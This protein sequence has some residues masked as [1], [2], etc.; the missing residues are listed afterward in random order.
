M[1]TLDRTKVQ[2]SSGKKGDYIKSMVY[3]GLDGIITTF[4]VVAGVVGGA[5]DLRIIIILGFSNLL[6]DGFSMATGDYLS[7][8]SEKEYHNHLQEEKRKLVAKNPLS[9]EIDVAK[10]YEA[11]GL[12]QEDAQAVAKVVSKYDVE[13]QDRLLLGELGEGEES[14]IKNAMVTFASFFSYGLVPL[15]AYVFAAFI[16]G[17]INYSFILAGVLTGTMLFSLG[18]IKSRVTQTSWVRSGLE[19]LVVG[20]LAAVF[21]YVVGFIL[22]K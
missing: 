9:A 12:S 14:P 18:A 11:R 3:G 15:L 22:G 19:M 4:A 20:G 17:I 10:E 7:S 5:L 1:R 13:I 6:A 8:K 16:P 2:K 21:A